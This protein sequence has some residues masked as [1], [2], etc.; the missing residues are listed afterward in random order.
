[1]ANELKGVSATMRDAMSNRNRTKGSGYS[2]ARTPP[3][4]GRA[5]SVGGVG[6]VPAR[7]MPTGAQRRRKAM[8]ALEATVHGKVQVHRSRHTQPLPAHS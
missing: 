5:G 7:K 4:P 6:R 8:D 3:P 2:R 1:M